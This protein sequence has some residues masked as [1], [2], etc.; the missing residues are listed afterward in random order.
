MPL[1]SEIIGEVTW[2]KFM[3]P[4]YRSLNGEDPRYLDLNTEWDDEDPEA[5]DFWKS[6]EWVGKDLKPGDEVLERAQRVEQEASQDEI[7][8]G[9]GF[10]VPT[11]EDPRMKDG[12][13][14]PHPNSVL[15]PEGDFN[16]AEWMKSVENGR[17]PQASL[18]QVGNTEFRM[19]AHAA[20]AAA[21]MMQAAKQDGVTL[22]IGNS[23]RDYATQA[24]MY[25][26]YK[27]GQGNL[28]ASPGE[29]NHGWGLAIDFN[30]TPENHRW[31]AA[32]AARFGYSNPFGNDYG[33][34]ENWHWEFGQG[35]PVPDFGGVQNRKDPMLKK[36]TG[37]VVEKPVA[38]DTVLT[39]AL[40]TGEYGDASFSTV[41][42]EILTGDEVTQKVRYSQP[43]GLNAIE[44]QLY[45]G[46][47]DSGRPDLARMVGTKDFHTWIQQESGWNVSAT[48]PA[49]NNG[50]ANDGLFQIWRGHAY[51]SNGQVAQMSPYE[52]AQIVA[53]YFGHLSPTDIRRYAEMIRAG[54]Y[55]GWG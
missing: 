20:A 17:I 13:R 42:A 26:A 22:T 3:Q 15:S 4:M 25:R 43:K 21:A 45:R 50:L 39:P 37:K 40:L 47:I 28:A 5:L 24:S 27:A 1:R 9:R 46:F 12:V 29:S 35:G 14:Q 8:R 16:L 41:L 48:S 30:I 10:S 7:A 55:S 11:V 6:D 23:Y 2:D 44:A 53:K 18:A 32:N 19:E 34:L 31:L 51:N 36:P 54:T 49:N 33:A 52:Q 38:Q